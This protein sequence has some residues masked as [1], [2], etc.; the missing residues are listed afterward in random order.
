MGGKGVD[1]ESKLVSGEQ[2][3]WTGRPDQSGR[4][5]APQI[6]SLIFG[7]PAILAGLW[8]L[9]GSGGDM[10]LLMIGVVA[11]GFGVVALYAGFVREPRTRRCMHYVLTNKRGFIMIEAPGGGGSLDWR[12][13]AAD[14]YLRLDDGGNGLGSVWFHKELVNRT[15][16]AGDSR[17]EYF[18]FQQIPD[19]AKVH[20]MI[21][22]VQQRMEK[23]RSKE[24]L[25]G[26]L[27]PN[28][29]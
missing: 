21:Q 12:D 4:M 9:A 5:R 17:T 2:V 6:A 25:Q 23:P 7:V 18:G 15:G 11:A 14:S 8:M 19:A 29:Q 27:D 1:W 3:L 16:E 22:D 24:I 28:G 20:A 13:I 26:L 10:F